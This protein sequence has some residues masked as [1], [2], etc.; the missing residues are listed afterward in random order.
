MSEKERGPY[1][2]PE[3]QALV[4]RIGVAGLR[5]LTTSQANVLFYRFLHEPQLTQDEVAKRM[6]CTKQAVSEVQRR[7]LGRLREHQEE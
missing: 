4:D 5:H 3:D 2:H 1:V 7:A 6:G